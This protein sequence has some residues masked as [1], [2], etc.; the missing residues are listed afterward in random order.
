R[1]GAMRIDHA[2]TK[3]AMLVMSSTW[4]RPIPFAEL[5]SGARQLLGE[6]ARDVSDED[7]V[8]LAEVLLGAHASGIVELHLHRPHWVTVIS[9]RPV[10][11][12]LLR[13]QL[14]RGQARAM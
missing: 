5:V 10:A 3:A 2:L 14:R 12:P 4:P 6:H 11:S 9:A 8:V 1:G 13:A 7:E